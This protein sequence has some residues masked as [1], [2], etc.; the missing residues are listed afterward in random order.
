MLRGFPLENAIFK[1][2]KL[3]NPDK[4]LSLSGFYYIVNL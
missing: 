2:I 1:I 3:K 4:H